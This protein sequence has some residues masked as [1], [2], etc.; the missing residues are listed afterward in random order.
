MNEAKLAMARKVVL[1]VGLLV[2]AL[3]FLYPHWRL[4]IDVGDG[5]PTVNSELGRAFI[6]SSPLDGIG[7]RLVNVPSVSSVGGLQFQSPTNDRR[8]I[9][10]RQF[11]SPPDDRRVIEARQVLTTGSAGRVVRIH[12]IRQITEVALALAFTFGLMCALELK[13]PAVD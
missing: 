13:K 5:R 11:Q 7:Q 12:Y 2:A 3:L 10:A 4:S 1:C 6:A 9:E 8:A